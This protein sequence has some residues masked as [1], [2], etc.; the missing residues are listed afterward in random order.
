MLSYIQSQPDVNEVILSGGDPLSLSNQ[1]LLLWLTEL[2]ELPQI[3]TI[4]I[5][6]RFPVVIPER[7][8]SE[9][10]EHFANLNKRLGKQLNLVMVIHCNHANEIDDNTAKHLLALRQTGVTLLNQAVLLKNINDTLGEQVALNRRVFEAGVLPYYL[11]VLDKVA[12]ASYFDHSEQFAIDLYWQMMA[13]LPGYLMPK[14]AREIPHK[15]FK[16][17]IDVYKK[18]RKA[19]V[20]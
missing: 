13:E 2:A 11:F 10:L 15:D 7:L 14:L 16:S 5:H 3:R 1:R 17:P 18:K 20:K 4:R 6:T 9:L 12:G 19:Q 8:D